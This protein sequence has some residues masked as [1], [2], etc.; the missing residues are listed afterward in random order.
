ML[1]PKFKPTLLISAFILFFSALSAHAWSFLPGSLSSPYNQCQTCHVSNS[2]LAMNAYG[3]DY[4]DPAFATKYHN[5]HS[6]DPGN[7]NNCHS[8][9]G[10]PIKQTGLDNMDSDGDAYTNLAEFNAGTFPGDATDFPVDGAAPVIT[11]FSLPATSSSL[12]VAV[13]SFTATDN[14][15]VTG[16]MLTESSMAPAAAAAGWSISPPTHYTF[17]VAGVATLYAWAKDAAGNVSAAGTAQVDTTPSLSRTNAPPVAYAGDDQAVTEGRTVTL[18]AGG[19]TDDLGIVTYAWLQLDGPGG[20]ALAP[21]QVDRVELSD[22]GGITPTFVTP[23]VGVNGTV[24]TFELTVTDGDGAQDVDEVYITIVDNGVGVFDQLEGVIPTL[25]ADGAPIGVNAGTGNAC[26]RL[27]TLT[28]REMPATLMQPQGMLY[29]LVD[30]D[31]KV[32]D[33]ANSYIVFHFPQAIPPGYKWYKF[34]AAR[35]WFDFDR[36]LISGGTGEGAVFS[37]DRTQ[38]TIYIDDN[39]EYDDNPTTGI[40]NDPGGLATGVAVSAST[41]GSTPGSNSFGA[42]GSG[43]FMDSLSESDSLNWPVPIFLGGLFFLWV[44][45]NVFSHWQDR[46]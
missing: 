38:V 2:N 39:S 12:T 18:D 25:S 23:P 24:L 28:L 36:D 40:I 11:A 45:E 43:C 4:L 33:A 7:C 13:D 21:G 44:I 27:G 37:P 31:L 20:S 9:K 6:S 30:F 1:Q 5:K 16:Y 8:G 19:S 26:T 29:G 22:P 3:Q 42:G 46:K 10:Y 17:S 15:A 35:G 14:V 41:S 32:I 34:T